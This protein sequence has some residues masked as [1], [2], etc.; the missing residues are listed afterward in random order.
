MLTLTISQLV[1]PNN[2]PLPEA[3]VVSL[4]IKGY[5]E[6]DSYYE[7]IASDVPVD[8]NGN[9]LDSPL[10]SVSIDPTQQYVLQAVN[11]MCGAIYTQEVIISPYCQPGYTLSDD[12]SVCSLIQTVDATPPTDP[13]SSVASPNGAYGNFGAFIY[14]PGYNVDGT[15]TSTQIPTSNGFWINPT[16]DT[17]DGPMNRGGLWA[18]VTTDDDQIVGFSVCVDLPED[19]TYYIGLGGDDYCILNVDGN[20]IITQNPTT[21]AAQYNGEFPGIGPAVTFKIWH[22]YP[23]ALTAGY[24][25]I[26]LIGFNEV[27]EAAIA[28]EIYNLTPAEISAATSYAAMGAGLIFSSKNYI[29]MPL[30]IANGGY[31]WTCPSGYSLQYCDSPPSCIRVLTTPVLY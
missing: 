24:H 2:Q 20:N 1:F 6:P 3:I 7:L 23:L 5:Y 10:P 30:Q 22:I 31:G 8:V 14:E 26:E 12:E 9:I 25:V 19:T 17:T 13:Q 11:E 21:L 18:P 28:A 4:S 16:A 27:L 15:G 29:G